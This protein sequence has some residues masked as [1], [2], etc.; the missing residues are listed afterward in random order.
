MLT[1]DEVRKL[2]VELDAAFKKLN[3]KGWKFQ[4][5]NATFGETAT[6]KLDCL[7]VKNGTTVTKEAGAYKLHHRAFNLPADGLSRQFV[8]TGRTFRVAGLLTRGKY[9]VLVVQVGGSGDGQ[10]VRMS[11]EVVAVLLSKK[12]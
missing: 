9:P 10:R 7:P 3:I 11:A 12:S 8:Y 1:R 5:G 4:L 6:F 2:R